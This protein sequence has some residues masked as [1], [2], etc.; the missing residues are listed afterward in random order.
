MP[1]TFGTPGRFTPP[2]DRALEFAR[3]AEADG[4]DAVWWPWRVMGWTP[5]SMW[6]EDLTPL[7]AQQRSP[8]VHFDPLVMMGAAGAATERIRVGV[9]VTDAIY[10]HPA[11]LAQEALTVDHLAGGRSILGLGAGER[12]NVTPYGLD[13]DKPVGRLEEC[14]EVMRRLW[15]ADGPI[16]YEGRFFRLERAVLGLEP[17]EGRPPAVWLA[18]H[19]PRMLRITGRHGDGWL[20]TTIGPDAYAAKLGVIRESAEAVGRDPDAITPSLLAYVMCAPDEDSLERMCAS[21][22]ARLLLAAVDLPPE[23]YARHGSASPWSDGTGFASFVPSTV[24][25]EEAMRIVDHITPG[26]VR[27]HMLCGT[28]ERIADQLRGYAQAGLRDVVLWNVTAYGDPD[29]ARYSFDAI[30][31]VK[32]RLT[33]QEVA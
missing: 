18:A 5:D 6:S 8:H 14:L 16:D 20:P 26:I 23:T 24:S 13:W 1:L 29:L 33:P 32:D 9:C 30:R 28:P 22:L 25:R 11:L 10:R 3:R 17:Y 7:A 21:P 31:Q 2:A 15:M 27:E 4:F 12:M 19:G